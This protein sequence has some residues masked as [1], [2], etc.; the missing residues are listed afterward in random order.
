MTRLFAAAITA[1]LLGT[2]AGA[3]Q[4]TFSLPNLTFP[5]DKGVHVTR[6][7]LAIGVMTGLCD[8]KG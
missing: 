5:P 1:V 8:P 4:I 2:S 7:C 3:G 6:N